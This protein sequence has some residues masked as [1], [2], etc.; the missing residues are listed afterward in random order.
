MVQSMSYYNTQPPKII[1]VVRG[2]PVY[3]KVKKLLFITLIVFYLEQAPSIFEG[4]CFKY[5]GLHSNV[6]G[7]KN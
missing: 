2:K 3:E 7:L 1:K 4:A 5:L 6:F